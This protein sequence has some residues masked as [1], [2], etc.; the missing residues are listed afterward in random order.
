[1]SGRSNCGFFFFWDFISFY[2][3]LFFWEKGRDGSGEW[4][5]WEGGG[6]AKGQG[7]GVREPGE[8]R[9]CCRLLQFIYFFLL[10]E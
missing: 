3:I 5:M 2:L 10:R 8:D 7:L 6:G 4:G 1:M 9:K